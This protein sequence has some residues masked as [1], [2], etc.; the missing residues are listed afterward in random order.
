MHTD[1]P[2]KEVTEVTRN[3]LDKNN[4]IIVKY[5]QELI[6]LLNTILNQN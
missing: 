2:L 1:I 4:N 6:I 5:K 3:T